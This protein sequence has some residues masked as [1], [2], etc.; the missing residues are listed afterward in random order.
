MPRHTKYQQLETRGAK[1]QAI[2]LIHESLHKSLLIILREDGYLTS[3]PYNT[4]LTLLRED[5]SPQWKLVIDAIKRR[6][7]SD[8][9]SCEDKVLTAITT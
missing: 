1:P 9:S 8:L 7:Q 5:M 2:D 6:T 3:A 4:A